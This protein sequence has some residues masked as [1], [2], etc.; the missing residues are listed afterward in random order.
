MVNGSN[1]SASWMNDI[2]RQMRIVVPEEVMVHT[3]HVKLLLPRSLLMLL[4]N[5][6][7]WS[8]VRFLS[9]MNIRFA[10]LSMKLSVPLVTPLPLLA[11]SMDM[12]SGSNSSFSAAGENSFT[13]IHYLF[14]PLMPQS[15]RVLLVQRLS[16]WK[17][18]V[19]KLED[20]VMRFEWQ[21][22]KWWRSWRRIYWRLCEFR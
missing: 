5:A 4:G 10:E 18:V 12:K 21:S 15:K 8:S 14:D 2:K 6:I 19:A 1:M 11:A 7:T 16:K 17:R 20:E 3:N 9:I 22:V 13:L